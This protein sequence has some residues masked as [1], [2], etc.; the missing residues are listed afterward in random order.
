MLCMTH[1]QQDRVAELDGVLHLAQQVW[2]GQ[3]EH[4]QP[5]LCL[6]VFHPLV[7][8]TLCMKQDTY[9]NSMQFCDVA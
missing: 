1:L 3:V 2:H 5:I 8:L 9:Q 4:A 7:G 6:H